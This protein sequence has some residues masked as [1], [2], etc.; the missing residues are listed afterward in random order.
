MLMFSPNPPLVYLTMPSKRFLYH[1]TVSA[2]LILCDAP[3]LPLAL[4]RLA[5]RSPGR[6]LIPS[7]PAVRSEVACPVQ[8]LL[9]RHVDRRDVCYSHAAVE[10]HSVDTNRR[11]VLDAE[12]DVFADAKAEVASL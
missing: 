4:L 7:Q 11:V 1:L 12:I 6:V 2:W 5:I 9:S 10:V 3:I 8:L